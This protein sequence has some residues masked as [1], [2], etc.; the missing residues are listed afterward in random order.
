MIF[1]RGR[2]GGRHAR[3]EQAGTGPETDPR[4][5][6]VEA[7][8]DA[9]E[10]GPYD[11]SEAPAGVQRLD[12]GSLQIPAVADV[13]VRV[14]ADPDGT[15][16][17]VVLVHGEN[18][19]QLGV[20]AAPRTEGIWDEVRE[21][22]RTSLFNDGVAAQETSGEYGVELRARV[23]AEGGLTDLRFVGIDGPRWMV[24]GVY[25]GPAASDPASAGPLAQVLDG[26][27]VD[28][29]Q[30]AKPVR[31]PLPLRLPREVAQQAEAGNVAA[32]GEGG[33][34]VNGADP[35]GVPHRD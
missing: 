9:P 1:S 33:P 2:G 28:R 8:S 25:Q 7:A 10:R 23:R 31:E 29:G 11:V 22:I 4:S 32:S 14:Q 21:E 26:L 3:R 20:F 12:L 30:E 5:A 24:R 6:A 18:A 16:Q 35:Y 27:V 13:E 34:G 17:Q 19:L 15:I